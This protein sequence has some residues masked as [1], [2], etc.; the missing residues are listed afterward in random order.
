MPD[1]GRRGVV[2]GVSTRGARRTIARCLR[3][4]TN[5]VVDFAMNAQR[6]ERHARADPACQGL[7]AETFAAPAPRASNRNARIV[8]STASLCRS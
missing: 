5:G 8:A 2:I 7:A 4:G 3:D 6:G 1:A